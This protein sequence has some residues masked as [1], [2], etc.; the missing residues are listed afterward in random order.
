MTLL[1]DRH[2]LSTRPSTLPGQ[3][4]P[5]RVSPLHAAHFCFGSSYKG[6]VRSL[7]ATFFFL[8]YPNFLSGVGAAE[9]VFE[10]V[11]GCPS[12]PRVVTREAIYRHLETRQMY[13]RFGQQR[14]QNHR[15]G[16][17]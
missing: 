13:V 8:A 3:T 4:I 11:R 6:R 16:T 1:E 14:V 7:P 15:V 17:R 12:C 5:Q 2:Q 9:I 10:S